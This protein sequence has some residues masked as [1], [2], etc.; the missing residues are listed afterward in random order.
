MF[1]KRLFSKAS[2]PR[3]TFLKIGVWIRRYFSQWRKGALVEP[4]MV[5]DAK[6]VVRGIRLI[7]G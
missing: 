7:T 3:R 5:T 4:F 1:A 6:L 2:H